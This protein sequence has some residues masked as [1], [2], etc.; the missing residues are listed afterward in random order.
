[1]VRS[2]LVPQGYSYQSLAAAPTLAIARADTATWVE[3]LPLPTVIDE[4]QLLPGL[5]LAVKEYVDGLGPGTQIVLTGSASIGRHGLGGADP[6]VRRARRFTLWPLTGWELAGVPG[7]LV[8]WLFD[9]PVVPGRATVT[10]DAEALASLAI[11]GFP[12]YALAEPAPSLTDMAA[13]VTSDITGLLTDTVLPDTDFSAQTARAVLNALVTVP[14]SVFNAS[15]IGDLLGLDRRTVDRYLGILTRLFLVHWLPN[16]DATPAR[17]G[18]IR[19]KVHPVDTSYSVAALRAAGRDLLGERELLGQVVESS[20]VNQVVAA[21][22]WARVGTTVHYWRDAASDREVDLVLTDD[23][24]RLVGIE[25]KAAR[26]YDSQHLRGLR[27]LERD[28]G[29]YRG[30]IVY[31]GDEVF[32]VADNIWL[33]PWSLLRSGPPPGAVREP[34][35]WSMTR[36]T[37]RTE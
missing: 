30:F 17:Q 29:L 27:A 22:G 6:L 35:G 15:R 7:S 12:D 11:G 18:H 34:G 28:R 23:R 36:D 16:L 26:V 13:L 24:G 14:G 31:L 25:V 5:P 2:H 9:G 32:P 21:A 1:M 10:P 3:H 8:D 19:A 37:T 4:A 20:V 33:L